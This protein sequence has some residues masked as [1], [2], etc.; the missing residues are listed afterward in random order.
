MLSPVR[1]AVSTSGARGAPSQRPGD[2]R[3]LAIRAEGSSTGPALRL[4]AGAWRK[5]SGCLELELDDASAPSPPASAS[6]SPGRDGRGEQ[7]EALPP[8]EPRPVRQVKPVR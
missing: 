4:S 1:C 8:A 7:Y 5:S 2:S 6:T 3:G